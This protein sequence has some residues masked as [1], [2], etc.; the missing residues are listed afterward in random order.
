M[1]RAYGFTRGG[2]ADAFHTLSYR[3]FVTPASQKAVVH[4]QVHIPAAAQRARLVAD[5]APVQHIDTQ[6]RT[7]VKH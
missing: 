2:D 5:N 3:G 1:M 4:A 6:S 7:S